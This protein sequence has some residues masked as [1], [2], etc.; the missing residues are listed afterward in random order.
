[1]YKFIQ[2]NVVSISHVC[3]QEA[4]K[5]LLRTAAKPQSVDYVKTLLGETKT[6][7]YSPQTGNP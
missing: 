5:P 6:H 2:Y 7:I 4:R 3:K 1:M